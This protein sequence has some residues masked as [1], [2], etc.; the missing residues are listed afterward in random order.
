MKNL[1]TTGLVIHRRTAPPNWTDNPRFVYI[2]RGGGRTGLSRSKWQNPFRIGRD[3]DRQTVIQEYRQFILG[4]QA[5]L[6][7]LES[8]R[9]KTLVCHCKPQACHGD[10]L[11]ELLY[12]KQLDLFER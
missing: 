4:Q 11:A 7:S 12:G 5:L 6:D 2:G 9:G 1:R 3:G 8:L 10:V